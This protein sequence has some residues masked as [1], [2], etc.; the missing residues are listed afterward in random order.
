MLYVP[1]SYISGPGLLTEEKVW[2]LFCPVGLVQLGL[3][4]QSLHSRMA[5]VTL[6]INVS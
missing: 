5:A 3:F 6:Y 1:H 4:S 2:G